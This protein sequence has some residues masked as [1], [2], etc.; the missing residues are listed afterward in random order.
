VHPSLLP[1]HRGPDPYYAVID[2]GEPVTGVTAH[3]LTAEY[4]EG[5]ILGQKALEVRGRNAWQLARALDRPSLTLLREIVAQFAEGRPPRATKQKEEQ[6]TWA[7]EPEGDGLRVDW[8]WPTVRVLNRI[9]ALSP[10]PGLGLEL[11]SKRFAV[12]AASPSDDCPRALLP[13]EAYI[14]HRLVLRTADGAI[15][16]EKANIEQE[17]AGGFSVGGARLADWLRH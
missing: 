4:D 17:D 8:S 5:D 3:R 16:V 13:G 10:I 14:G 2:A 11:G 9:R 6:A 15:A 1:R 12:L 7:P